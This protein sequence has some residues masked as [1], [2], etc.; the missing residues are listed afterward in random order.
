MSRI[1]SVRKNT[2]FQSIYRTGKSRANRFFIMY[3][4][5]SSGDGRIGISVSKKVGNSVVRHRIKRLVK[6]C[7]RLHRDEI[8]DGLD[9]IVVARQDSKD[10]SYREIEGAFLHLLKLQHIRIGKAN[11]HKP[12]EEP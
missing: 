8:R 3:C 1:Q 11:E 9:I 5:P 7:Y 12:K 6:E 2:E 4:A 10:K